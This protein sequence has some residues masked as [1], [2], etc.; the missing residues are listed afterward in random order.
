MPNR[1]S[2]PGIPEPSVTAGM[3]S[4]PIL[5]VVAALAISSSC[6]EVTVAAVDVFRVD[7]DPPSATVEIGATFRFTATVRDDVGRELIRSITWSSSA[8]AVLEV[9]STGEAL[10]RGVGGARVTA[11]VE[12]RSGTAD[13]TVRPRPVSSVEVLPS[14]VSLQVDDTV[15]LQ[16][17]AR[18]SD[19]SV[20]TGRIPT[21][22]TGDPAVV[23]VTPDGR[24]VAAGAGSTVVTAEVEGVRGGAVVNVRARIVLAVATVRIEPA[25]AGLVVGDSLALLAIV[26]A[27][28]GT[29]LSGR[30]VS[31]ASSTPAV[32]TVGPDGR[33]RALTPGT[34]VV[35]AQSE[36]IVG[37]AMISVTPVPVASVQL[38]PASSTI[39][40]AGT[41]QIQATL[42]AANGTVLTGRSV[43]WASDNPQIASVDNAGLVTGIQPGSVT[44][45]ATAEGKSGVA[46][47]IVATKPVAVVEI[48]PDQP[49]LFVDDTLTLQALLTAADATVLSGR[50]V[51]WISSDTSVAT[52]V[53]NGATSQS[54]TLIARAA[55]TA[56]VTALAEGKTDA[57][58]VTVTLKPVASVVVAPAAVAL[59]E[60]QAI[61]VAAEVRASDGTLLTNRQVAWVSLDPSVATVAGSGAFQQV[62]AITAVSCPV[63]QSSCATTVTATAEGIQAAVAVLVRKPVASVTVLPVADTLFEGEARAFD[64]LVAA[65][66]GTVLTDRQVTWSVSPTG[67]LGIVPKGAFAQS[68]DA[69]AG[70]CP[71]GTPACAA[72]LTAAVANVKGSA[73]VAILKKVAQVTISP[74]ADTVAEGGQAA[75]VATASASDATILIDRKATWTATG[76]PVVITPSGSF[77]H[78]VQVLA[79][80][81]P[82]GTP[83]S[84]QA[85]LTATI[86]GVPGKATLRILT[87]VASIV[88]AP[89]ADT[90]YEGGSTPFNATPRTA[91]GDVIPDRLVTWQSLDSAVA[92]PAA[93][94]AFGH[95]ATVNATSKCPSGPSC[96][97][98]ILATSEGK[99]ATALI[100]VLRPVAAITVSPASDT[101]FEGATVALSATVLTAAGDTL[102]DRLVQWTASGPATISGLGGFQLHATVTAG[103]CPQGMPSCPV[104]ISA[105]VE[106]KSFNVAILVRKTV[107]TVVVQLVA[108]TLFEAASTQAV[109]QV[110][111]SD[112]TVLTDR[113]VAWSTS[114]SH[115]AATPAS[116]KWTANIAALQCKAWAGDPT[117]E[118]AD[119][120]CDVDII[121]TSDGV[122][123]QATLTMLKPVNTIDVSPPNML[124]LQGGSGTLTAILRAADG[125]PV[126]RRF[127]AIQWKVIQGGSVTLSATTGQSVVVTPVPQTI[128]SSTVQASITENGIVKSDSSVILVL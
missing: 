125:A 66:D 36:G 81:C 93:V 17:V 70:S 64:A 75:F 23:T 16:A 38:D 84:C 27:S 67:S 40:V 61:Q 116:A 128:G 86:D 82:A 26:T 73:S 71:V 95:A 109:A 104:T 58:T 52:V 92:V 7:V 50:V 98:T 9:S 29:V 39:F 45:S 43:A 91:N 101:L 20:L 96:G 117:D 6:R 32:A 42:R 77:G 63:G 4:G 62:A 97:T 28:D 114:K 121:A 41:V 72:A 5:G 74:A 25:A 110:R 80:S 100:R 31:W 24:A 60:G 118:D 124:L 120:D 54:A 13:V 112:G 10:A 127:A 34:S 78:D 49:S 65:A 126:T 14:S 115:A 123:G 3:R 11:M 12:G 69:T 99:Q 107:A 106:G 55:G 57:T 18:A 1:T 102:T 113:I 2:R 85:A 87:P 79:G 8:P 76:A 44:I 59:L 21:W 103:L 33:V 111:A 88:I 56:T 22:T 51:V 90:V 19:G 35:T 119:E 30:D 108:D 53:S 89:A 94:G 68:V 48:V 15:V 105:Q 122:P 46:T 83:G 47:V 37:Q